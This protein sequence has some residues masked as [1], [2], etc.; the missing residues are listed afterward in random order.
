MLVTLNPAM[1]NKSV[2]RSFVMTLSFVLE[3]VSLR[4]KLKASRRVSCI[5]MYAIEDKYNRSW[6]PRIVL[7]SAR[8]LR[9]YG[10]VRETGGW[11]DFD[12][13]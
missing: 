10:S 8:D 1:L 9:S 4:A 5:R 3:R 6:L 11:L 2:F 12:G 13:D 7:A